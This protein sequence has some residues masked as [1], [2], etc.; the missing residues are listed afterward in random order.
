MT[1][2]Q[3]DG[4]A[5]ATPATLGASVE[6]GAGVAKPELTGG[7]GGG[8]ADWQAPAVVVRTTSTISQRRARRPL[9]NVTER[10]RL[11][12]GPSIVKFLPARPRFEK[13]QQRFQVGKY[14]ARTVS[15]ALQRDPATAL[16]I[17]VGP[18]QAQ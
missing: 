15:C 8:V 3:A 6:A 9:D 17:R 4:S 11:G 7:G 5:G 12:T 2:S 16:A 1:W 14:P 10:I 13:Q 18:P